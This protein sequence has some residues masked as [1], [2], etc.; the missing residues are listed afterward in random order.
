MHTHAR[1]RV[2]VRWTGVR[3]TPGSIEAGHCR[4]DPTRSPPWTHINDASLRALARAL[5]PEPLLFTGGTAGKPVKGRH[6]LILEREADSAKRKRGEDG[7]E[8]GV[9]DDVM[10]T[11]ADAE[12]GSAAVCDGGLD[13][14]THWHGAVGLLIQ[15][16]GQPG[17]DAEWPAGVRVLMVCVQG[18]VDAAKEEKQRFDLFTA[19]QQLTGG[20][21]A[22]AVCKAYSFWRLEQPSGP[23]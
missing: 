13:H 23:S 4:P 5:Q 7:A 22:C 10:R 20:L 19:R 14:G 6:A 18:A 8:G 15:P 9:V 16:W 12:A 3:W 17:V 1:W 21:Q 2:H 11:G